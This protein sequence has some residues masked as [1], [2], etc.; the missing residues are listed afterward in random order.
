MTGTSG[1]S[2]PT[3]GLRTSA[4]EGPAADAV[5]AGAFLAA[6][7]AGVV[8]P[9][10]LVVGGAVVGVTAPTPLR[11]LQLGVYVGGVLALFLWVLAGVGVLEGI[12]PAMSLEPA[13]ARPAAV[14]LLPGVGALV[15]LFG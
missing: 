14:V 10:G 1:A 6:V 5:T 12:A 3:S 15:R 4:R 2:G 13:S 9:A 8:H 7:V 11:A